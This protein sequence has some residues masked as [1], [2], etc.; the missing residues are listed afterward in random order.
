MKKKV[1]I[2]FSQDF[3][4]G[5]PQLGGFSRIY[6]T[7]SDNNE[8]II[9]TINSQ[10]TTIEEYFIDK[11]RVVQIPV[12]TRPTG[13]FNQFKLYKPIAKVICSHIKTENIIPDLFFGHSHQGNFLILQKVRNTLFKN[14]KIF[15]EAN[16]IGGCPRID[17]PFK[18][19]IANRVQYRLQKY[20]FKNA[21]VIV[22]QTIESKEFIVNEF[23]ISN[24]KIEVIPNAI[25]IQNQKLNKTEREVKKNVLCFGLF[26]ELNGIPFLVNLLQQTQFQELHFYFAGNGKYL[27]DIT[28]LASVNE[29]VTYLGQLPYV[30]MMKKMSEFDYLLIPRVNT[31]GANL[32][33]PTKLLEGMY[34]GLI[35][36]CSDVKG[37]TCVVENQINGY[38][39]QSNN[40]KGLEKILKNIDND[41]LNSEYDR[42]QKNAIEK[43]VNEYSWHKNHERL[44]ELYTKYSTI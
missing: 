26:D 4:K 41:K 7:C 3:T 35:P 1:I 12:K 20:V 39:F 11:I 15:W 9:Y 14:K 10:I 13:I 8:H 33:I 21:D 43:V 27:N 17:K 38:L 30:E 2:H 22:A 34:Y 36:I 19:K 42:L 31:L 6:N 44:E 5:K 24:I 28:N 16:G 29:N 23:S 32:Y 37:M 18:A 40:S 25:N